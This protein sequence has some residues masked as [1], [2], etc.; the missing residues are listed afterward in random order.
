VLVRNLE[1]GGPSHEMRSLNPRRADSGISWEVVD[2]GTVENILAT[3]VRIVR[4]QS[5]LFLR[6]GDRGRTRPESARPAP[7]TLRR[8]VFDQVTGD[9][10]G[11]RGS[12]FMGLADKPIEDVVI[13][14]LRLEVSATHES[15][16]TE[17]AVP[18][19]RGE[20]PDAHMIG[21]VSPAY[22]LWARHVTGLTL[23]RV[24]FVVSSPDLR[25]AIDAAHNKDA[26]A[27]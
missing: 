2:G 22:G 21:P 27:G 15:V 8:I 6:L 24:A 23:D 7:G 25:P 3:Q 11:S 4:A 10:N 20:Y 12:Y 18:E 5:P 9:D 16:P 13:R 1:V 26:C 14:D 17:A 19:L